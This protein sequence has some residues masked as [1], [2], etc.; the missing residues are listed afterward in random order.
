MT[1]RKLATTIGVLFLVGDLA[2][3]T[4]KLLTASLD[5]DHLSL[6]TAHPHRIELAGLLILVMGVALAFISVVAYP[7]LR[8]HSRAGAV[9]YV[10]FRGA[11]E[12]AG[13]IVSTMAVLALVPI[14]RDYAAA[15][16][17][18]GAHRSA[19]FL[20]HAGDD[21]GALIAIVFAISALI[22]S[23]VLWQARLVPRW[24]AGWGLGGA[25]LYGAWGVIAVFHGGLGLLMVPLAV[26]E[27]VLAVW[28]IARGFRE[29]VPDEDED[30]SHRAAE[31]LLT[32]V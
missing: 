3:V 29:T 24:L 31:R 26:E 6:V 17:A 10:V 11:L 32:S 5:A 18:A 27:L 30:T 14:V 20:L 22:F 19:S 15:G 23:W 1:S 7:V 28:L 8:R 21:A 4:A 25:V 9:G 12:S 16:D 13:Y 2:G